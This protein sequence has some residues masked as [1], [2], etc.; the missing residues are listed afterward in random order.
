MISRSGK[1]SHFKSDGRRGLLKVSNLKAFLFDLDGVLTVG[2]E[3]LQYVGGKPVINRLKQ[4]GKRT[5]I[6]TNTSTHTQR[7]VWEKVT[8][9]GFPIKEDELMT[10]TQLMANYLAERYGALTCYVIGEPGLVEELRLSG[11]KIPESPDSVDFVIVGLD[12]QLTYDK[13][14]KAVRLLR[15]N[16]KL[17]AAYM[18]RVY[19]SDN[20]PAFSAGPTAKALEHASGKKTLVVGKPSPLMFR[21]ALKRTGVRPRDALMVGDQIDTDLKGAKTVG[22]HT[23]LV[24][25]GV[26]DKTAISKSRTKP[27]LTISHVDDLMKYL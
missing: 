25:T 21:L 26:S 20:G 11:H 22:L 3:T 19:M 13:L 17:A 15:N 12:R 24:L 23:A 10:S 9:L 8:K 27:D 6:L 16:A 2:K 18:D 4:L 7:D 1:A 14:N 5:C